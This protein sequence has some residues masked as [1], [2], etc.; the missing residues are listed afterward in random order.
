MMQMIPPCEV[1]VKRVKE[2]EFRADTQAY[3]AKAQG[4]PGCCG[5]D[6]GWILYNLNGP[7][8]SDFVNPCHCHQ[9]ADR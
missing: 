6:Q 7:L 4:I 3:L 5:Q 8:P 1:Q 9:V 2:A